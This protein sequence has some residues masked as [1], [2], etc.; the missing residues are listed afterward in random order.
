MDG[1]IARTLVHKTSE[2]A[3]LIGRPRHLQG[4]R[5]EFDAELPRDASA[6]DSSG[7]PTLLG[8][9]LMRQTAI[10]YT[11]LQGGVPLDWALLMKELSFGWLR[12]VPEDPGG[13]LAGCVAVSTVAVQ[14]RNGLVSGLELEACFLSGGVPLGAG[15]GRLGCVSRTAYR[16][17]RRNAPAVDRTAAASPHTGLA[18]I[19]RQGEELQ[20]ELVWNWDDPLVF[21]HF[22]DHLPGILLARGMLDAHLALTGFDAVQMDIAC[23]NFGEFNASAQV[24]AF[25]STPDETRI[26]ISQLGRTLATGLCRGSRPNTTARP[27][28]TLD[29]PGA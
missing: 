25:R 24:L 23:E 11:H 7:I 16:A 18:D 21:D 8:I 5:W 29:S 15:R 20:A 4:H 12:D 9:E 26:S 27:L 17:I 6:Q 3:V 28:L 10:A 22:P 1:R 2:D 13:P 19:R 14:Q